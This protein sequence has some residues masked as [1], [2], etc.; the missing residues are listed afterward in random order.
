MIRQLKLK[1]KGFLILENPL[2]PLFGTSYVLIAFNC[3]YSIYLLFCF[4]LFKVF[5]ACYFDLIVNTL[6]RSFEMIV[7]PCQWEINYCTGPSIKYVCFKMEG[8]D[9]PKS[10][11]LSVLLRHS[12]VSK[13]ARR[14]EMS[15]S[16]QIWTYVFHGRFPYKSRAL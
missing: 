15:E 8:R 5:W 10:I 1:Q 14:K 11:H 16:H 3:L 12:I 13:C 9:Q 6:L 2:V 7:Y 4:F